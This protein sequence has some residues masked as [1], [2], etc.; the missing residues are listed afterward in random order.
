MGASGKCRDAARRAATVDPTAGEPY[1]IIGLAYAA[2]ANSFS[3]GKFGGKEVYWAAVDKFNRAAAIDPSVA[4]R[5]NSLAASY[6]AHFPSTETIFFNDLA[7]GQS[8]TV[9]GWIGET[10]TIRASK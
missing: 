2:S 6:R 4:G 8:Y 3:D 1:I 5:A 7:E 10:T 9:G